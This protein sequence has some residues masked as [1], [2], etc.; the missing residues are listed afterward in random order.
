MTSST[1]EDRRFKQ[2]NFCN[3]GPRP[4]IMTGLFCSLLQSHF[5]SADNIE[6]AIY[7]E[8][9]FR[10]GPDED[11]SGHLLIDDATVW[12]PGR[13]SKRPGIIIKRN[14]WQHQKRFTL[15]SSDTIDV[16]G[17]IQYTKLWNGSHT[18]FCIGREGA[19]TEILAAETYRF[20]M[21]FGM[22]FRQ[23]FGLLSFEILEVGALASLEDEPDNMTV[24][25]TVGYSWAETWLV[26]ENVATLRDIRLSD[27]FRTY[28]G[29][30]SLE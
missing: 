13:T 1:P 16:D 9:I 15:D 23:Y 20:L 4:Q 6:S 5:S 7:R 11:G 18:I 30:D 12:T 25:I 17:N 14:A 27:I 8:R 29:T 3:L 21:H 24:P 26:Q 19:E 10:N 2:S 22:V 28:Y